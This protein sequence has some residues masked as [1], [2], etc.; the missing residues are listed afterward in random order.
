MA[1]EFFEITRP[2]WKVHYDDVHACTWISGNQF[3]SGSKDNTLKLWQASSDP[4]PHITFQHQ[5]RREG[6]YNSWITALVNHSP[7][8]Q[9]V[10]GTRDGLLGFSTVKSDCHQNDSVLNINDF[11]SGADGR[12]S[13]CKARNQHRVTTLCSM[14][15][16]VPNDN[17]LA[18]FVLVGRPKGIMCV[19]APAVEPSRDNSLLTNE[20]VSLEAPQLTWSKDTHANDWVYCILPLRFT[21]GDRDIDHAVTAVVMGSKIELLGIQCSESSHAS[22]VSSI[23][24]MWSEDRHTV[25][26]GANRAHIAHLERL[27]QTNPHWLSAAC[28]DGTARVFDIER[29]SLV[30]E[31]GDSNRKLRYWQTMELAPG[32]VVSCADDGFMKLWDLRTAGGKR[33]CKAVGV[34]PLHSGRVSCMLKYNCDHGN[35]YIITASCPDKPHES[36]S[37]AQFR[38]F[39]IRKLNSSHD[40][41][42]SF[43]QMSLSSS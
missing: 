26:K 43:K 35:S 36:N 20:E 24:E 2:K 1:F 18:N 16:F 37:K 15:E 10:Y 39:D 32:L 14:S 30:S 38:M 7:R 11:R 4:N 5:L 27:N 33:H 9:V 6:N 8:G 22:P 23:G 17:P 28:F 29:Q 21:P 40:L 34:S 25:S 3:V 41:E 42:S 19:H 13:I 31:F 12:Q